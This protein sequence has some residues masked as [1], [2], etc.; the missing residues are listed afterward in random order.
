M[1]IFSYKAASS[2]GAVVE[3]VIEAADEKA[4][5]E[6]IKNSGV[7]LL[8][9][10]AQGEKTGKKLSFRKSSGDALLTFT[11]ELS[12]LLA[13]G[14]PLDRSL[15]ILSGIS[16]SAEMKG[17]IKTVLKSIREGSSFSDALHKHPKVFPKIYI[18]I[19]KAGEAG[20]VLNVVLDK[21][22]EF[23]ETTKEL[24]EHIISS[25]IYPV[26]LLATGGISILILM[27]FMLP[28]FSKIFSELGASLPLATRML[29]AFSDAV[30]TY[31][32]FFLLSTAIAALSLRKYIN[33]DNGRY[34]YD[35]FKLKILGDVIRKLETARFCR[36]LGTLLK[37]GVPMLQALNNAKDVVNNQVIATA[38]AAVSRGVKEGKGITVPLTE[39]GVL[40]PLALSMIQV[41][42]E[43]GQLDNMLITVA[44]TYEKNL[45]TAIKR[46]ISL[47]EPAMIL[48]MGLI[49]GFIVLSML[50][51]IFT[52][53]E[54]PF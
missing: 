22:N 15:N 28:K 40:P 23:L 29:L 12:I 21:L 48:V 43:T 24:K 42:E 13:A 16:E 20:G 36:T 41:G 30:R 54:A 8:K 35:S 3:G 49:I 7:I 32:W 47:L 46:F 37:S 33:T 19:I 11:T 5:S 53:S 6:R 34:Q 4:A 17:I 10:A 39:A 2:D 26:I 50:M 52:I 45:K 18:N 14:L 1:A 25:M 31:W 51:G 38:I 27:T 9:I 44:S